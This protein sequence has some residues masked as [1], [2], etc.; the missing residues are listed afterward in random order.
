MALIRYQTF[1]LIRDMQRE[2]N[3]LFESFPFLRTDE[4]TDTGT[5]IP[6]VDVVEKKDCYE[7]RADLPGIEPDD[8]EVRMD[9][10]TLMIKGERKHEKRKEDENYIRYESARGMFYREF[11]LPD[12]ADPERIEARNKHGVLEIIVPKTEK[13]KARRIEVKSE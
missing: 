11:H 9:N 5:W 4:V 13:S 10:G 2:I 8:I 12:A 1:P 3:R 7:I 6:A